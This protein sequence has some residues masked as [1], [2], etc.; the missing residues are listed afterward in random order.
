MVPLTFIFHL[1]ER[2]LVYKITTTDSEEIHNPYSR[3]RPV[4]INYYDK[5]A[6]NEKVLIR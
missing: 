4:T 2:F 1:L 6:P 5:S 3:N